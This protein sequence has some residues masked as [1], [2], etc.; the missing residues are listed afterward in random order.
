M[1]YNSLDRAA[2]SHKV[3]IMI[4]LLFGFI[5]FSLNL[6]T[7]LPVKNYSLNRES[8]DGKLV[9][10]KYNC[11]ACHQIYGLG[12][13]LG[14]D[15]TNV[16]SKRDTSFITVYLKNGT[17]TMPDFNL[18]SNEIYSLLAYFKSTDNSGSSDPRTF[19]ILQN[20]TIK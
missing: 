6:Y 7:S 16:Y 5:S 20:G 9:W 3:I 10:Q 17:T 18:S 19:I 12:G 8:V 14:P 11:N 15:L 4:V 1:K 13:Y 2:E